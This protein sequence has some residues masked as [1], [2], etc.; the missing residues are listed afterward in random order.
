VAPY[1]DNRG[2][3]IHVLDLGGNVRKNPELSGTSPNVFGIQ[4]GVGIN[5][6]IRLSNN[7]RTKRQAKIR[8]DAVPTDWRREQKYAFLGKTASVVGI[9]WK[10]LQPDAKHN[11]LVR[12]NDAEFAAF[13]PLGSK[14]ARARADSGLATKSAAFLV[15]LHRVRAPVELCLVVLEAPERIF[16]LVLVMDV[17]LSQLLAGFG[18]CTEIGRLAG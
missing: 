16:F 10:S 3:A 18:E 12:K 15:E 5:L 8:F 2:L 9:K 17:Q 7:G 6:F 4:V 13:V 14:A 1:N 11:W